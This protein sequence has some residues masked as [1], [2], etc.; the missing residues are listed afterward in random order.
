MKFSIITVCKNMGEE[1]ELSIQSVSKQSCSDFEYIVIDGM[2]TDKTT[3][4]VK[5]YREYIDQYV[6]ENDSGIYEAMNK[7][8]NI[9]KGDYLF[10]LNA[11]DT[12]FDK[13]TLKKISKNTLKED[14][15]YGNVVEVNGGQERLN[16]FDKVDKWFLIKNAICHQAMFIHK[17]LFLEYGKYNTQNKIAAD[18]EWLLRVW[19]KNIIK[20]YIDLTIVRFLMGGKSSDQ[21]YRKLVLDEYDEIRKKYFN[22][23][24]ICRYKIYASL[25]K[26]YQ[27]VKQ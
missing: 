6:R 25:V 22:Y 15:V 9:A 20:K 11:G 1:L 10:F 4:I 23:C 12:F 13:D 17:N 2:S 19:D 8:I 21:K 3:E 14:L 7:A 27:K 16:K 24:D 5:K 26:I 18:Y